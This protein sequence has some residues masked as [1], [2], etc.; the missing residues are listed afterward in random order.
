M[1]GRNTAEPEADGDARSSGGVLRSP[2]EERR[3][4][5]WIGVAVVVEG[6]LTSSEDMTVAGQVEGDVTVRE[7]TL[8]VGPRATIR[9]NVLAQ[10]VAVHG[11]VIGAIT[12]TQRLE[13]GETAR[14]D[15]DLRAPRM[16]VAE[17]ARLNSRVEVTSPSLKAPATP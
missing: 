11:T 3:V 1:L 12:A 8:V 10:S 14:V 17:G 16:T 15:G 2:R 13:V 7:H 5:A 4:A 6:N 9:G